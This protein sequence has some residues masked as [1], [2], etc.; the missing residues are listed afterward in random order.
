[1]INRTWLP[2]P[3]FAVTAFV[4][5]ETELR[6]SMDG[7]ADTQRAMQGSLIGYSAHPQVMFW[8]DHVLGLMMYRDC[9]VR[10]TWRRGLRTHHHCLITQ[11]QEQHPWAPPG[12]S[13]PAEIGQFDLHSTMRKRL[14]E[15]RRDGWY[16]QWRWGDR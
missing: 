2:H 8:Q 14:M 7:A 1:M 13:I 5:H 9:L 12:Y 4:L 15:L 3:N 10:E 11:N 6:S 16:D